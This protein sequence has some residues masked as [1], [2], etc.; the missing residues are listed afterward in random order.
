MLCIKEDSPEAGGRAALGGE[1]GA[2]KASGEAGGEVGGDGFGEAEVMVVGEGQ[3]AALVSRMRS[4]EL[5][6]AM[7]V[8]LGR[9]IG[10]G[11]VCVMVIG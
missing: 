2:D 3:E 5:V 9:D 4:E 11:E 8:S 7:V 1:V 10:R 6:Q